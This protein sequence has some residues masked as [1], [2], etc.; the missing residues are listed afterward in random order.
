MICSTV[1]QIVFCFVYINVACVSVKDKLA[2][3]AGA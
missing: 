1:S 2:T 3:G